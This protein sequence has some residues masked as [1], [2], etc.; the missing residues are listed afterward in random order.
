MALDNSG[1]YLT[2]AFTTTNDEIY[3]IKEISKK[4]LKLK[5]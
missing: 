4:K 3:A 1:K 5:I 2:K